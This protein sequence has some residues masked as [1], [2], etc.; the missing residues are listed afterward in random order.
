MLIALSPLRSANELFG[1]IGAGWRV[2]AVPIVADAFAKL[3][4]YWRITDY[5]L[6]SLAQTGLFD[7]LD[8]VPQ[9]AHSGRQHG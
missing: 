1:Q 7:G 5:D 3:G 6:G 8:S 2:G 9:D 4:A